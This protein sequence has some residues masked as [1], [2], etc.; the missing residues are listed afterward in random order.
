MIFGRAFNSIMAKKKEKKVQ[1]GAGCD[2]R[3]RRTDGRTDG[4]GERGGERG[5]EGIYREVPVYSNS[6]IIE[7]LLI[8][9][10]VYLV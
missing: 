8:R 2:Y 6:T 5:R 7:V 4:R 3:C 10:I 9:T 1:D